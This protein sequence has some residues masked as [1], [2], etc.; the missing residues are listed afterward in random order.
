M[1]KCHH[2]STT[3]AAPVSL[4]FYLIE[5]DDNTTVTITRGCAPFNAFKCQCTV[6]GAWM[7]P[8]RMTRFEWW[9]RVLFLCKRQTALPSVGQ[10]AFHP[11][12]HKSHLTDGHFEDPYRVVKWQALKPHRLNANKDEHPHTGLTQ[13]RDGLEARWTEWERRGGK[14]LITGSDM[15]CHNL[16]G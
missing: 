7:W 10:F 9:L 2:Y 11:V 4:L 12:T 13:D 5:T 14:I 8:R 6:S 15:F 3:R 16:S 1:Q